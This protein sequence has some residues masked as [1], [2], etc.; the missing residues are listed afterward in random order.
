MGILAWLIG[1]VAALDLGS[2]SREIA[3]LLCV[4]LDARAFD[5][6]TQSEVRAA[7]KR[8]R[9]GLTRKT[10]ETCLSIDSAEVAGQRQF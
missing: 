9:E 1:A 6:H 3:D 2:W 4:D 10:K 7:A 8:I 5:L